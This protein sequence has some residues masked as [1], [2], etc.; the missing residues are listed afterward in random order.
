MFNML[1]APPLIDTNTGA[2]SAMWVQWYSCA[3]QSSLEDSIKAGVTQ[4]LE[5]QQRMIGFIRE[6]TI[7]PKG[8]LATFGHNYNMIRPQGA[9]FG[10]GGFQGPYGGGNT[11]YPGN[12]YTNHL[13]NSGR[14]PA[15]PDEPSLFYKEADMEGHPW[16]MYMLN[17]NP[18]NLQSLIEVC[19]GLAGRLEKQARSTPL[20]PGVFGDKGPSMVTPCGHL[21]LL[22]VL[23][24]GD[25]DYTRSL[26]SIH[27]DGLKVLETG[28]S[29]Q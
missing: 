27:D 1:S 10:G 3:T 25:R 24:V 8:V 4:M 11:E 19:N 17:R 14:Y 23:W 22:W 6:N 15:G 28:K 20:E 16:V 21:S 29:K 2:L 7:N 9:N 12:M 26:D 13:R 5:L 18:G